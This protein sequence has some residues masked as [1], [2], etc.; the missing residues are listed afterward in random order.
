MHESNERALKKRE[1]LF[2]VLGRRCAA[3]G[4]RGKATPLT[5]DVIIP[6]EEGKGSDGKSAHHRAYSWLMRM[7]FYCRQLAAGNL[8]V[9]CDTCNNEKYDGTTRFI[10][11]LAQRIENPF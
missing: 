7:N 1:A 11:P 6:A 5:F 2:T 8:Q 9:L 10:I 3:C 4:K